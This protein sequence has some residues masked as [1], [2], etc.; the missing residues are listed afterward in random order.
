MSKTLKKIGKHFAENADSLAI[1]VVEAVLSSLDLK[2]SNTEKDQAI[3]MYEE[4][5]G[6][7][8]GSVV[9]KDYLGVPDII[10][11][12]SK[13][14]AQSQV[15]GRISEIVLRYSPTREVLNDLITK[16]SIQYELSLKENASVIKQ[17]NK[18]FDLS[19]NETVLAFE[20]L[21]D[22]H[23]KEAQKEL[24]EL[25]APVVPIKEGVAIVPLIGTFDEYRIAYLG[26]KVLP[27]IVDMQVRHL[28]VDY[29][30]VLTLDIEFT[31]SLSQLGMVLELLD[32][33]I[34][35]TGMTPQLAQI[36]VQSGID[37]GKT[38]YFANLKQALENL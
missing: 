11:E 19:L 10:L 18:I 17:V 28:I 33:E 4:L 20:E 35:I 9:E 1:E 21:S 38:R 13:K 12:W 22:K 32:I 31:H 37:V 23:K 24:A 6:F 36:I 29:S 26:N 27:K 30:G 34:I 16:L 3:K 15:G 14:N 2:I 7:L 5:F 25:S 8:G